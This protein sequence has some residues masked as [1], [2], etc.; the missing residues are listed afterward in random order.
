MRWMIRAKIKFYFVMIVVM[1][2]WAFLQK[3]TWNV[4]VRRM[5]RAPRNACLH[6]HTQLK[7]YYEF[8]RCNLCMHAYVGSK[9][10][11]HGGAIICWNINKALSGKRNWF[12]IT[13]WGTESVL[14]AANFGRWSTCDRMRQVFRLLKGQ[15]WGSSLLRGDTS[16]RLII[17]GTSAL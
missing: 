13:S 15:F 7:M 3:K 5:G 8:L 2:K 9:D 11:M 16:R 12:L 14:P 1:P 6:T 10:T 4:R 17:H